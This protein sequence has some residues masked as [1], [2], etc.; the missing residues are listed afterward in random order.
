[1]NYEIDTYDEVKLKKIAIEN[2]LSKYFDEKPVPSFNTEADVASLHFSSLSTKSS[3]SGHSTRT[4]TAR[5]GETSLPLSPD[6]RRRKTGAL[7]L[8]RRAVACIAEQE[9][10][11]ERIR[12]SSKRK[13]H[14]RKDDISSRETA[15]DTIVIRRKGHSAIVDKDTYLLIPSQ[16]AS[17]SKKQAKPHHPQ[18]SVLN[19]HDLIHMDDYERKLEILHRRVKEHTRE[20]L[21]EKASDHEREQKSAT[22]VKKFPKHYQYRD[23]DF[24]N[25][26][27]G[28]R[29]DPVASKRDKQQ[30]VNFDDFEE[31]PCTP[32]PR[33]AWD[34]SKKKPSK[35]KKPV[36]ISEKL[37]RDAFARERRKEH[38][39]SKFMR[40][41]CPFVPEVHEMDK[42]ILQSPAK[43]QEIK[44]KILRTRSPSKAQ[45]RSRSAVGLKKKPQPKPVDDLS[46]IKPGSDSSGFQKVMI[47]F[48]EDISE[49]NIELSNQED[50][51]R[52]EQIK[53]VLHDRTHK[54]ASR[55]AP[56]F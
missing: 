48:D 13:R 35:K 26:E 27:C 49:L 36:K 6:A 31:R 10:D 22:K 34:Y 43:F 46:S 40:E 15:D 28:S 44:D 42:A 33:L 16:Q 1:M 54:K 19:N 4:S 7:C 8:T 52:F 38:E 21:Q 18:A 11:D 30:T 9:D 17:S 51:D 56:D 20:L 41:Y 14:L 32:P 3:R 2:K 53:K 50:Q 23:R 45:N 12:I 39:V 47:M 25:L 55:E 24:H 29:L 5:P 37:Y